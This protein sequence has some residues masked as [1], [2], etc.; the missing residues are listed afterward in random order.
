M[1]PPSMAADGIASATAALTISQHSAAPLQ[2]R[3]Q[4]RRRAVTRGRIA[5]VLLAAG[6]MAGGTL[7]SAPRAHAATNPPRLVAFDWAKSQAGKPYIYGGTGPNGY[8]CSG[9]VYA[10]YKRAG[11][12]LPRTTNGHAGLQQVR[13]HRQSSTRRAGVLRLRPRRVRDER[14]PHNLR[15]AAFGHRDLVAQVVFRQ[16]MAS[17]GLPVRQARRLAV[18]LSVDH[19]G[20][21]DGR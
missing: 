11:F 18:W 6:L 17:H 2:G 3:S 12:T 21:P 13:P 14:T 9:L 15:C 19:A 7:S 10:A 8:D 1:T 5:A 16:L 4:A 20:T